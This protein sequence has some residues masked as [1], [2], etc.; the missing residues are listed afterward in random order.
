MHIFRNFDPCSSGACFKPFSGF[1]HFL[2]IINTNKTKIG[3]VSRN[4][5]S[6]NLLRVWRFSG[7]I[8]VTS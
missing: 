8:F 6:C 7:A 3:S 5:P 2:P 1:F 4:L